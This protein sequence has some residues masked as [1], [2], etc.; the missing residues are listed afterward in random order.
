MLLLNACAEEL[1]DVDVRLGNA[2]AV[3]HLHSAAVAKL[4]ASLST[5][6]ADLARAISEGDLART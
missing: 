3:G 5:T 1:G 2:A 4:R 6:R